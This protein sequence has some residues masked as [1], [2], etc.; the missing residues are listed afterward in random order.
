MAASILELECYTVPAYAHT[1]GTRTR[2]A[3]L[4]QRIV[5][6]VIY[7]QAFLLDP[8]EMHSPLFYFRDPKYTLGLQDKLNEALE[9]SGALATGMRCIVHHM[10]S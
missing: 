2:C 9:K 8:I 7:P 3:V 1:T 4:S 5:T 10:P 6:V